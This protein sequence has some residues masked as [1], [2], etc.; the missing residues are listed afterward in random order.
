MLN[1]SWFNVDIMSIC[2]RPNYVLFWCNF[3]DRKIHA[4]STHFFRCNFDGRKIHVVCA[5]F[6]WCNFDGRKIHVSTY[7]FGVIS[8]V[9]KSRLFLLTL[10]DVILMG[11]NLVSLFVSFG[12]EKIWWGFPAFVTLNSSFFQACSI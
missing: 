12:N 8:L 3:A 4:V 5:Y 9:D 6:F 11:K 7:F 2:R 10:F 1:R